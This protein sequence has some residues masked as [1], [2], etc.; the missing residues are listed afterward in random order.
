[1]CLKRTGRLRLFRHRSGKT[2]LCLLQARFLSP[3][4]FDPS[5]SEFTLFLEATDNAQILSLVAQ[6]ALKIRAIAANP[7]AEQN[8]LPTAAGFRLS[9]PRLKVGHRNGKS[10]SRFRHLFRNRK[11]IRNILFTFRWR[12]FIPDFSKRYRGE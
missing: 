4:I 6:N 5:R 12:E 2:G 10:S 11:I 3:V 7:S 8:V 9:I 1:M